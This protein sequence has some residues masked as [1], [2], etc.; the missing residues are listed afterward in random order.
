MISTQRQLKRYRKR[1]FTDLARIDK[2]TKDR[3]KAAWEASGGRNQDHKDSDD[4]EA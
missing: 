2:A 1:L 4:T 3:A